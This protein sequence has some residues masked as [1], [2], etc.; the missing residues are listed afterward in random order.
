MTDIRDDVPLGEVAPTAETVDPKDFDFESWLQGARA[1][2]RSV[3]VFG[4]PDLQARIDQIRAAVSDDGLSDAD[5]AAL[6]AEFDRV[7]DEMIASTMTF[8]L[9]KR[10][11]DWVRHFRQSWCEQHG[12]EGRGDMS[13]P[14]DIG[15]RTALNLAQAAA[16]IISPAVSAAQIERLHEINPDA[17]T[18]LVGAMNSFIFYAGADHIESPDFSRRRSAGTSR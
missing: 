2:E 16:M 8:T 13:D 18:A 9:R 11:V 10:S 6:A 7:R 15:D 12:V 1:P 4:R 14:D 3:R 17:A 5:A